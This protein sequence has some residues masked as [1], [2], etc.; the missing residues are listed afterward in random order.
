V[1]LQPQQARRVVHQF[2]DWEIDHAP[3]L[4]PSAR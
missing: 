4:P 3:I 2:G 1:L